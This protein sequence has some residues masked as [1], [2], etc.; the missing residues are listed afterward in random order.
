MEVVGVGNGTPQAL[1]QRAPAVDLPEP[2]NSMTTIGDAI[3]T[4]YP[5]VLTSH[6]MP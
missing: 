4:T 1:R 3:P 2:E 6:S 5:V